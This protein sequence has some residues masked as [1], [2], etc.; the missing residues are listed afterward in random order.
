MIFG[1]G[2]VLSGMC[3]K[4]KVLGFLTLKEGWDPSLEFV[5]GGAVGLNL[6]TF[7]LVI[8]CRKAP[9]LAEKL[10]LPALDKINGNLLLGALLFGLG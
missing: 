5:L 2:L 3:R 1:S 4:S 9:L 10:I 6:I 8:H 7:N